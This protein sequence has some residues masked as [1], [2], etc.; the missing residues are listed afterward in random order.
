VDKTF[1]GSV[2]RFS[3]PHTQPRQF[4]AVIDWGD[5]SGPTPG[6]VRRRGNGKYWVVGAHRYGTPGVFQVTVTIRDAT[7]IEIAAQGVV[8]A[9][10]TERRDRFGSGP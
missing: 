5:Q 8:G 1:H 7:G 2:A 6:R 4:T 3:D 9:T 10:G